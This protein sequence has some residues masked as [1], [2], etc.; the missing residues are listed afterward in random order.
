MQLPALFSGKILSV[1]NILKILFLCAAGFK[2]RLQRTRIFNAR[3]R[4]IPFPRAVN[5][6]ISIIEHA[7]KETLIKAYTVHLEKG[8]AILALVQHT[9]FMDH[10]IA[11]KLKALAFDRNNAKHNDKRVQRIW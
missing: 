7:P 9:A 2:I 6:K 4:K 10:V 8:L 5:D 1:N 11:V 3:K